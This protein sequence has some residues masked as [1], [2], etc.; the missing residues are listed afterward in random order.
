M[1]QKTK[2]VKKMRNCEE[3]TLEEISRLI[4]ITADEAVIYLRLNSKQALD[5]LVSKGIIKCVK[6]GGRKFHRPT[7]DSILLKRM[8]GAA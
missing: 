7:L 5:H 2:G 1:T 3:K 4:W 8:E 6:A